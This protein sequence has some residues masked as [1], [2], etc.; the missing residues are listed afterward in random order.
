MHP[1][2]VPAIIC[3]TPHVGK[4]ALSSKMPPLPEAFWKVKQSFPPASQIWQ[5]RQVQR[6]RI[7]SHVL[8][9]GRDPSLH[10]DKKIQSP[11]DSS[12][13]DSSSNCR[14]RY[15]L[16]LRDYDIFPSSLV[17]SACSWGAA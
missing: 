16:T 11:Q 4:T 1:L 9:S 17:D 10:G 3:D 8:Q 6:E 14:L 15:G 7:L 13:F 12:A 5:E 2:S